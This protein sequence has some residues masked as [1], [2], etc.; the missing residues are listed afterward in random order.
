MPRLF[1]GKEIAKILSNKYGF[2]E[3]SISGSHLKVRKIENKIVVTAI[4]PLHKE[5]LVGTFHSILRQ[6]K[7]KKDDFME[8][9]RE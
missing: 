8:K 5:I 2:K 9:S 4:I 7:I 1:S 3:I 6:A